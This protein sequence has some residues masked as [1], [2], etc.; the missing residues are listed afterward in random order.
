MITL[1]VKFSTIERFLCFPLYQIGIQP[2]LNPKDYG[3]VTFQ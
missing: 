1:K 2:F 3:F